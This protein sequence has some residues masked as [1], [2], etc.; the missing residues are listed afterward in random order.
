M[1]NRST[2]WHLKSFQ[3]DFS[4]RKGGERRRERR[5]KGRRVQVRLK[6]TPNE[7]FKKS[8]LICCWVIKMQDP[9]FGLGDIGGVIEELIGACGNVFIFFAESFTGAIDTF[10]NAS[11]WGVLETC[12]TSSSD[13]FNTVVNTKVG[14]AMLESMCGVSNVLSSCL[15]YCFRDFSW[16]ALDIILNHLECTVAGPC[17]LL[18][19]LVCLSSFASALGYSISAIGVPAV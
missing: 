13:I 11:C 12:I 16:R 15:N 18:W 5:K 17:P 9:C 19:P 1:E 6:W 8:F 10:F 2:K 7:T 14:V 4:D 3:I